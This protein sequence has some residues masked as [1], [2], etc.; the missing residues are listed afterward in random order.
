MKIKPKIIYLSVIILLVLI[1]GAF[2]INKYVIEKYRKLSKLGLFPLKFNKIVNGGGIRNIDDDR[3]SYSRHHYSMHRR[4][5]NFLS[6][7]NAGIRQ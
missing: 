4:K 3:K 5:Y 2:I 7:R 6:Q 1:S